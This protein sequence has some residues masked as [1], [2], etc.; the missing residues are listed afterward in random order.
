MVTCDRRVGSAF[1]VQAANSE[2]R[3]AGTPILGQICFIDFRMS[4]KVVLGHRPVDG[5]EEPDMAR[6]I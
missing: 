2:N 5:N 3:L 6:P 4:I 1:A